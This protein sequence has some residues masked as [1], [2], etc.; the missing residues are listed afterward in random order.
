MEPAPVVDAWSLLSEAPV[1]RSFGRG[2]REILLS[3]DLNA[4]LLEFGMICLRLTP[5]G[6]ET[7]VTKQQAAELAISWKDVDRLFIRPEDAYFQDGNS[8]RPRGESP[9]GDLLLFTLKSP[10]ST[11]SAS[12]AEL[13]KQA[14]LPPPSK[15]VDP[16]RATT[17][18]AKKG[19]SSRGQG[20]NK[21]RQHPDDSSAGRQ[22][23]PP[24]VRPAGAVH[25]IGYLDYSAVLRLSS[26]MPLMD[27]AELL[28][29]YAMLRER[30]LLFWDGPADLQGVL[31]S[32]LPMAP[33]LAQPESPWSLYGIGFETDLPAIHNQ[34][35]LGQWALDHRDSFLWPP[36]YGSLTPVLYRGGP[37][38]FF[39]MHIEDY[40]LPSLNWLLDASRTSRRAPAHEAVVEASREEELGEDGGVVWYATPSSAFERL[41]QLASNKLREQG[42]TAPDELASPFQQWCLFDPR[43]VCRA[44]IPVTRF[45]Q[46]PGDIIVTAPGAVHWGVNLTPVV[47]V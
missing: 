26:P 31:I 33:E 6:S 41:Q 30:E 14:W 32:D 20:S 38:S 8:R 4:Q 5:A 1:I 3:D 40:A 17:A 39:V 13:R 23:T 37:M 44:G 11:S 18:E 24:G 46:R 15:W 28:L 19:G 10:G 12:S 45:I 47:K 16:A 7:P 35:S 29:K 27:G 22:G 9:I 25:G 21:K 36:F 2:P 42:C 43:D 34:V